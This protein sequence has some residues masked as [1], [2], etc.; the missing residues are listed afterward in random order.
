[1]KTIKSEYS[2]EIKTEILQ[3]CEA[4]GLGSFRGLISFEPSK[5]VDGYI[6]TEFET[7]EGKYKHFFKI[8]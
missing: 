1:M 7:S 2:S 6:L 3:I 8:K 5:C 4:F